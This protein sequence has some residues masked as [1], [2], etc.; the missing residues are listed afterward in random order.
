MKSRR[1][2]EIEAAIAAYNAAD[3]ERLL[4]P[5]E[6]VRLLAVMFPRDT[7]FRSS[8]ASL[9]A[10]GFDRKTVI[11]LVESLIEA[12]FLSRKG[13]RQG[14]VSAYTLHLPRVQP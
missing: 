14:V 10:E 8:V 5:P 3:Q 12:G 2:R 6:A 4:L 11:K 7:V 9:A 13:R 1:H